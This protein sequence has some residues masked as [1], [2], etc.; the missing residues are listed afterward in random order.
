MKR[1]AIHSMA[2]HGKKQEAPD[3]GA[4]D[5]ADLLLKRYVLLN[6]LT[7]DDSL[8]IRSFVSELV[9]TRTVPQTERH[10]IISTLATSRKWLKK[11]FSQMNSHDLFLGI[12]AIRTD[13][14]LEEGKISDM[15]TY[16][17]EFSLWLIDS[18]M[19]APGLKREKVSRIVPPAESQGR[20]GF[21]PAE[22]PSHSLSD[23]SM[24]NGRGMDD[25][26]CTNANLVTL[27]KI[28][29]KNKRYD[30]AKAIAGHCLDD[31]VY[32]ADCLEILMRSAYYEKDFA[33]SLAF[34]D[35]LISLDPLNLQYPAHKTRILNR[36]GKM[37]GSR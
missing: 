20:N 15:I 6:I 22:K 21:A 25:A 8:C 13:P 14:G 23:D 10:A 29:Q 17:R 1:V 27:A 4:L 35:Q 24:Q 26:R 18:D 16:L 37:T 31:P 12:D 11:P 30:L 5:R 33:A 19:A 3:E 32:K 34:V 2:Y 36:I 9:S 28:F 7:E